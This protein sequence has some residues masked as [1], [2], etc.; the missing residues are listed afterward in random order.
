MN[1]KSSAL[2]ISD[3]TS[4][5]NSRITRTLSNNCSSSSIKGKVKGSFKKPVGK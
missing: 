5:E 3:S 4:K 1:K 2:I